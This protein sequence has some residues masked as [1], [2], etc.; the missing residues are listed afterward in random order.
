M[1]G[2]GARLVS[3]MVTTFVVEVASKKVMQP[4]RRA[5]H[6][7]VGRRRCIIAVIML[8]WWKQRSHS[9]K[10]ISR[11]YAERRAHQD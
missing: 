10:H 2:Q 4:L 11:W 8:A 6:I 3:R 9:L 5:S 7:G 1:F